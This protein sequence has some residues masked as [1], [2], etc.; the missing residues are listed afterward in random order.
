MKQCF[1]YQPG[2]SLD[3]LQSDFPN[4]EVIYTSVDGNVGIHGLVTQPLESM[5]KQAK[6]GSSPRVGEVAAI[7]PPLMM[8][9]VSEMSRPFGVKRV[10]SLKSVMI[11]A[12]G[13]CGACMVPIQQDEKL[14]RKHA[15]VDG[16]EF[17]AHIIDWV[18][19]LPR[20]K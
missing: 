10:A 12:T 2:Q 1:W 16:P 17:D 19:L 13:M 11:D 4:L 8:R 20:F 5:L 6:V 7:G 14:V 9:V 18:K 15:C 3:R